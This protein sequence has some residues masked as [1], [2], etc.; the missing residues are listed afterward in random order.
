MTR[1]ILKL[2]EVAERLRVPVPTL[3][4]QRSTG[5]DLPKLWKLGGRVVA[6]EDDVEAWLDVQYQKAG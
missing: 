5:A 4:Y 3:R 2:E 6:Y 1:K